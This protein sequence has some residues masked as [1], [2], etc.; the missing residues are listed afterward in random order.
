MAF[1]FSGVGPKRLE[2][3][4]ELI[5]DDIFAID[6]KRKST[7]IFTTNCGYTTVKLKGYVICIFEISWLVLL[8]RTV[9]VTCLIVQRRSCRWLQLKYHC[10]NY[11]FS[12]RQAT[13]HRYLYHNPAAGLHVATQVDCDDLCQWLNP[14]QDMPQD[15]A[16]RRMRNLAILNKYIYHGNLCSEALVD[17]AQVDRIVTD[18]F[19]KAI[20][21]RS[22]YLLSGRVFLRF[23]ISPQLQRPSFTE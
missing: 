12:Q 16:L 2:A 20:Q 23:S 5:T 8:S 22:L 11:D 7:R 10:W 9:S 18:Q 13:G 4:R 17:D 19:T 1:A 21:K 15:K 3:L 14:R 6:K